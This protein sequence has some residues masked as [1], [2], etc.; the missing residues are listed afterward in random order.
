MPTVPYI[1][2]TALFGPG[3]GQI[4]DRIPSGSVINVVR[5][6][7]DL[8]AQIGTHLNISHQGFAV[9]KNGLLYF[10]EASEVLEK[11]A[12]VPMADYLR[13]YLDSPTIKGIDVL[14]I[15]K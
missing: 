7:W 14:V 1:P 11:V 5:P 6:N 8:V 13:E 2:L 9:R 10:L 15:A 3:G 4:F 12:M